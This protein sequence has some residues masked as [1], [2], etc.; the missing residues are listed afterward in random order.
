MQEDIVQL[1]E[2]FE[3]Q[4]KEKAKEAYLEGNALTP[5]K[6]KEK[7]ETAIRDSNVFSTYSAGDP[8][9]DAESEQIIAVKRALPRK[10]APIGVGSGGMDP[11]SSSHRE[12]LPKLKPTP[13]TTSPH[14]TTPFP[15]P[16]PRGLVTITNVTPKSGVIPMK[17]WGHS[18]ASLSGSLYVFGGLRCGKDGQ[19]DTSNDLHE[20]LLES[21]AWDPCFAAKG[22]PPPPRYNASMVALADSLF[23]Y[24]GCHDGVLKTDVHEYNTD[25]QEWTHLKPDESEKRTPPER[26]ECS[27]I[28]HNKRLL[29]FGGRCNK[30]EGKKHKMGYSNELWTFD[31]RHKKWRHLKEANQPP[32]K[33]AGHAVCKVGTVMY[34][35]GGSDT[36]TVYD[37]LW[38]YDIDTQ[39]WSELSI[40]GI[41]RHG[42]FMAP[43]AT[44]AGPLLFIY[45]GTKD[46]A[47][48]LQFTTIDH[49]QWNTI[50]V[51][52]AL[53]QAGTAHMGGGAMR[54]G[55]L[56]LFG[57][58]LVTTSEST[59][60]LLSMLVMSDIVAEGVSIQ[61]SM[62]RLL[63]RT[64]QRPLEWGANMQLVVNGRTRYAHSSI[65]LE[66][67][68]ELYA[69]LESCKGS[70]TGSRT[71]YVLDGNKRRKGL[72][73][74]ADADLLLSLLSF[75]YSGRLAD[76]DHLEE[77]SQI[78][79]DLKY[80][81]LADHVNS[82]LSPGRDLRRVG[83][84]SPSKEPLTQ[85]ISSAEDVAGN[86][87]CAD[88]ARMRVKPV[89]CDVTIGTSTVGARFM[90]AH[91]AVLSTGSAV[92]RR[93]VNEGKGSEGIEVGSEG[94]IRKVTLRDV[95]SQGVE[96]VLVF[97]YTGECIVSL[98]TAAGVMETANLL[99]LP[100][101]RTLCEKEI[102]SQM[103]EEGVGALCT[104]LGVAERYRATQLKDKILATL[105]SCEEQQLAHLLEF[106]ILEQSLQKEVMK[107]IHD[108]S[109]KVTLKPATQQ[110]PS[111]YK[112]RVDS[113][114]T[115]L[116]TM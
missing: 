74:I 87:L 52:G 27:V 37:D 55:A 18:C 47:R 17:R 43:L 45:G 30:P 5:P 11:W 84:S 16:Q 29:L 113:L 4:E 66:R 97:L 91:C 95:S 34:V 2:E 35:H 90:M 82:V 12:A 88:M 10:I 80:P 86:M 114:A 75:V 110:H 15:Y 79:M 103:S 7:L 112:H 31:T 115:K 58:S 54:N 63:R 109:M 104:L 38:K 105:S 59:N 92:L 44:K 69:S 93:A 20:Y 102:W 57:G 64:Q 1:L 46:A 3:V 23:I 48:L 70:A 96:A 78:V 22:E 116:P 19:H 61:A 83:G 100:L 41:P 98:A 68:P 50:H 8:D 24:G 107:R 65:I 101:L 28:A 53:T 73:C 77:F 14:K 6:K 67:A 32:S 40:V 36:N 71:E 51:N 21:A 60:N 33:R 56:V 94:G 85:R 49:H 39:T 62:Q 106:D 72:P 9:P 76:Y 108:S 26:A 99:K 42:H 13:E 81:A 25:T 111:A 89:A